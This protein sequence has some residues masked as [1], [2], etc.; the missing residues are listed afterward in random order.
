MKNEIRELKGAKNEGR[1]AGNEE[2]ENERNKEVR[3][4]E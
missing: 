3:G 4:E 1:R 2:F